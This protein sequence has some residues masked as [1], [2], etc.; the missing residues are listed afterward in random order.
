MGV[1]DICD[2]LLDMVL[3]VGIDGAGGGDWNLLLCTGKEEGR[4]NRGRKREWP[5][6]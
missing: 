4:C 6:G 1:R 5:S 3:G 2:L